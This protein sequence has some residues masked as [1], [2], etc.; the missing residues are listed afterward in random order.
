MFVRCAAQITLLSVYS[1]WR[2]MSYRF[3]LP[4]LGDCLKRQT[5]CA[6]HAMIGQ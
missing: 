4:F 6:Q 3:P 5:W 2:K 1:S